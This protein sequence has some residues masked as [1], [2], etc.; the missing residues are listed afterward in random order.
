M[1]AVAPRPWRLILQ[2]GQQYFVDGGGA[3]FK[4]GDIVGGFVVEQVSEARDVWL[5]LPRPD[6]E[7]EQAAFEAWERSSRSVSRR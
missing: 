2:T 4:E 1:T 6:N 7:Q 3:G 5:R